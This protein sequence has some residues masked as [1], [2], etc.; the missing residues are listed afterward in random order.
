[1]VEGSVSSVS[2]VRSKAEKPILVTP[3]G[4]VTL[5]RFAQFWK[6][7]SSISVT[8]DGIVTVSILVY[9]KALPPIDF[10]VEGSVTDVIPVQP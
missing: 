10:R 4:M 3:S 6:A 9:A 5:V 2:P 7:Y 1:M 8:L